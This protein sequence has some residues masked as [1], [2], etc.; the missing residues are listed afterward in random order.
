MRRPATG[1]HLDRAPT[2]RSACPSRRAVRPA[3]SRARPQDRRRSTHCSLG[4]A[5][6]R[7]VR[8]D[9]VS[10]RTRR[11][12]PWSQ[13]WRARRVRAMVCSG[14][15]PT[16]S[17]ARRCTRRS[18]PR[19]GTPDL[20]S[21]TSPEMARQVRA[22]RQRGDAGDRS[23]RLCLL[24]AL[25]GSRARRRRPRRRRVRTTWCRSGQARRRTG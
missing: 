6:P 2:R 14:R 4:S 11:S 7:R 22:A 13:D 16:A 3:S 24:A 12:S 10:T 15:P 8:Q 21:T 25:G 23:R 1:G 20:A 9:R 19:A 17:S 5:T 18:Q